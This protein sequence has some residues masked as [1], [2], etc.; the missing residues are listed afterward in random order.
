MVSPVTV[1]HTIQD[2][3]RILGNPEV[4]PLEHCDTIIPLETLSEPL[5]H[6]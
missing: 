2:S 6:I 1:A 5:G 3:S 4:T